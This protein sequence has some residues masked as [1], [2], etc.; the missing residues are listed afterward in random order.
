M[1]EPFSGLLSVILILI[2]AQ[3]TWRFLK[4]IDDNFLAQLM[5]EPTRKSVL[6]DRVSNMKVEESFGY[7]NHEM[8]ALKILREGSRENSSTTPVVFRRVSYIIFGALLGGI[9]W[10]MALKSQE[11][12]EN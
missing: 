3:A 11:V 1:T 12:R 8:V 2:R 7:S 4:C 10:A 9:P 5:E 6:L